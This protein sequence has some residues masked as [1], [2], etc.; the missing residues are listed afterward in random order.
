[1][2]CRLVFIVNCRLVCNDKMGLEN[3]SYYLE[4]IWESNLIFV[5]F[6][7]KSGCVYFLYFIFFVIYFVE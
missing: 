5:V 1:M 3:E 2:V 4:I 6:N 7:I